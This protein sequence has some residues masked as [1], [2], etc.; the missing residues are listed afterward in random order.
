MV[1]K[2]YVSVT[3]LAGDE[4]TQEQVDR[5]CN[6]YYWAGQYC[7]DKDVV[8][9]ACGS[10]QGLG[11]LSGIARSLEAGDYSDAILSIAR[12]HYGERI[13]LRQFDAQDMPFEDKSK[14]VIIL[15]EAIYYLPDAEKFVRECVRVLR[16]GGKVLIA[17]AN[18]DLYDFNPSPHSY[19]YHGVVELNELFSVAGF[20]VQCYGDTPVDT[21]SL[22]QRILR[23]I[24]K[25]VVNLK[26]MPKSMA[27]KKFIK[28][29]VFGDLVKMPA[30]IGPPITRIS[31]NEE[32]EENGPQITQID[33]DLEAK[34]GKDTEGLYRGRYVEPTRISASRADREH[35]VI[36]CVAS[37]R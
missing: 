21:V 32:K 13:A 35:K 23:P 26:L 18:K 3:E 4:V 31:R 20:Q 2:D 11:Y 14:D 37:L 7:L 24:K 8:E 34:N 15:F 10:G 25:I 17:T 19:R 12:Q 5:L 1:D 30:E 27:G 28:R 6:R 29:L 22:R 33:A 9:A 16:P 36:Y